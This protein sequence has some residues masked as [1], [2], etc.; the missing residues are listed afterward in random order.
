MDSN[1]RP[2]VDWVHLPEGVQELSLWSTL[3]DGDLI[4]IESNLL[5]RTLTL[6][7]DVGYLRDFHK[8][9]EYI[10]FVITV[11]GVA[12]VRSFRGVPWP[13]GCSIPDGT[14][15]GQQQSIVAEYQSKWREE[16][17][18]WPDFERFTNDGLEVSSAS[19]VI[20]PDGV[21]LRLGLLVRGDFYVE[22][23]FRGKEITFTI[24]ERL[25]TPKE[26]VE[27]GEAY[28]EAFAKSST[29]DNRS[30]SGVPSE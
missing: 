1:E 7:F 28:W 19:L 23:F 10:R 12:S 8:F 17:L 20:E 18:S 15:Y 2:I 5:A 9:P 24:G 25:F 14:P 22:A 30:A 4:A 26:F 27:L 3:H 6:R 13:G 16:S 11:S 29:A 21:A